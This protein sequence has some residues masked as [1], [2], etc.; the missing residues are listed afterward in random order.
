ME[1]QTPNKFWVALYDGNPER[2]GKELDYPG[3]AREPAGKF[4]I[5]SDDYIMNVDNILFNP[6]IEEPLEP[7]YPRYVGLVISSKGDSPLIAFSKIHQDGFIL[8]RGFVLRLAPESLKFCLDGKP[9]IPK[10]LDKLKNFLSLLGGKY[11]NP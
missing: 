11:G 1:H 8:D 6:P 9:W 5:N 4:M 3:Y 7:T 2:G 10:Q